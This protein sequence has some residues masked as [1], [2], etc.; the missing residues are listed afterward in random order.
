MLRVADLPALIAGAHDLGLDVAV[1][2]TLATPLL[3]RP[4]ELGPTSPSTVPPKH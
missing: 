4:L 1:D 2:N 3:Q